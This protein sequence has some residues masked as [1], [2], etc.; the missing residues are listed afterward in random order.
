M[1]SSEII[2]CAGLPNATPLCGLLRSITVSHHVLNRRSAILGFSKYTVVLRRGMKK[3][4][5]CT[6]FRSRHCHHLARQGP[7]P[8]INV[9]PRRRSDDDG[10]VLQMSTLEVLGGP[11]TH[12]K[13]HGHYYCIICIILHSTPYVPAWGV[14]IRRGTMPLSA[15]SSRTEDGYSVH[16][17]SPDLRGIYE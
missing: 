16:H 14:K 1:V 4:T 12:D 6:R 7:P 3:R 15:R 10:T 5:L 2:G 9:P 13:R 11:S 17:S 8:T